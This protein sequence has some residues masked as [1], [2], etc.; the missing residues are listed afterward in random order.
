MRLFIGN[1]S[2][3]ATEDDLKQASEAF[4]EVKQCIAVVKKRSGHHEKTIREF[5]LIPGEGILV[6]EPLKD[7]QGVLTGVPMFHG[8]QKQMM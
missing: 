5:K 4:G 2:T 7:F 1:L 6:G 3:E 8:S